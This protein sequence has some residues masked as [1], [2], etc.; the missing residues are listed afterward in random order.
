MTNVRM[1]VRAIKEKI[2][3]VSV[4]SRYV[5]LAKSGSGYKG[6][7][8]FHKDDT[9]SFV[10][11]PGKGLWHCFGCG[12]GGD[13]IAFLM[14]IEGLSF[15]EA[16]NQLAAEAGVAFSA[17][18]DGARERMR[19]ILAEAA[20]YFADNLRSPAGR[21]ARQYLRNRGYE[22][23]AWER[24]GLGFALPGWENLKGALS[25]RYRVEELV[26]LGLLVRGKEGIYDRFR[27][28]TIFTIFDLSGR[29]IAFGGRAFSGE[30]K[31]LNSPKTPLFDKGW[32]LYGLSW[33]RER[34]S[35]ERRAV[36][37]EGYTD[38]LTLHQAGLTNAV[39][40]MGTSLTRGQA[41]LL[42]R[43]VDEVVIAYDRDAAGGAAA[44]RGMR[45]LGNSG[46]SVRVALFGEGDDPDSLLRRDGADAMRA[47]VDSAVPFY[48]FY[49]QSLASKY[50][51]STVTGKERS[52][53]EAREFASGIQ[54]LPLQQEFVRELAD[55]LD[56]PREGVARELARR[57]RPRRD[58]LVVEEEGGRKWEPEEDL[59]VLLLR[60][61]I[62]WERVGGV[63]SPDH[64]SERNRP[65]VE[66]LAAGIGIPELIDRLDEES[67]RR[68][69]FYA[70]APVR[71]SDVDRAVND[72]V[73][74]LVRL[75]AIEKR[76]AEIDS[77]IS[78]CER[79]GNLE[80]WN[81]LTREKIALLTEK[82]VRRGPDDKEEKGRS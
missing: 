10:V 13:V 33:A 73:A 16:A 31:Y 62:R 17:S 3:I 39:G 7:C 82:I 21:K 6:R 55:L 32:I 69:S 66:G 63:V 54:S 61:D 46:L 44:L 57:G 18:E 15:I 59:L 34:L 27:D 5:S 65:I 4:I 19:E 36:L 23:E 14:K 22:E 2:D 76:L 43:F 48:R 26:E 24:F 72:A 8:P 75:P 79:E 56:L 52:L 11:S 45:I 77:E 58:E 68:A 30:P 70:L 47:A 80:R 28:R 60:G 64:F 25:K 38:V 42:A 29:P 78:A 41:E 51:L 1:D 40:S 71:F 35:E 12:E 50:D 37:V 67:A 20:S 53:A 81:E 49:V 74:R 9:P